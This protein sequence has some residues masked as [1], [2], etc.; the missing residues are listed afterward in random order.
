MFAKSDT[1]SSSNRINVNVGRVPQIMMLCEVALGNIKKAIYPKEYDKSSLKKGF[2]KFDSIKVY[3][4]RGPDHKHA[5]MMTPQGFGVTATQ[6]IEAPLVFEHELSK[7]DIDKEQIDTLK[8]WTFNRPQNIQNGC[9]I[10]TME[11]NEYVVF[12]PAQVK[13]RYLV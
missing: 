12:N 8:R 1:Y 9:Q 10:Y 3:G 2:E 4:K 6:A 13:I 5:R 11:Y 7:F